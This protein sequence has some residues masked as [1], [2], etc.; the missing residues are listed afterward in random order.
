MRQVYKYCVTEFPLVF[1]DCRKALHI[2]LNSQQF[3]TAISV[4]AA[5]LFSP[6]DKIKN[7][8]GD[9]K[10]ILKNVDKNHKLVLLVDLNVPLE[11]DSDF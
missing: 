11:F 10:T 5:T 7:F 2:H 3:M 1:C 4:Y 8:H 6:Q 9:L